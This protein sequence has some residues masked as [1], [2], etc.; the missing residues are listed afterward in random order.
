MKEKVK[1]LGLTDAFLIDSKATST[2]E[3]GNGIYPNALKTLRK[4]GIFNTVHFA[5]Q[6]TNYDYDFYDYIFVM[7]YNNLKMMKIVLNRVNIDKAQLIGEFIKPGLCIEDP[8][9]T[10]NFELV[11][12]QLDTAINRFIDKLKSEEKI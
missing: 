12:N 10:D 5:K 3:I 11:Y 4:H 8:W 1:K 9:Y 6:I 7:D 2:E